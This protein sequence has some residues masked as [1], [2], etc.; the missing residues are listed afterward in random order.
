VEET[1]QN[2]PEEEYGRKVKVLPLLYTLK[3]TQ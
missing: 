1:L 2:E 3:T